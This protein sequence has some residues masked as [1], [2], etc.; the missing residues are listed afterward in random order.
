MYSCAPRWG[1]SVSVLDL[2]LYVR[3]AAGANPVRRAR[4]ASS[5]KSLPSGYALDVAIAWADRLVDPWTKLTARGCAWVQSG[6]VDGPHPE[7]SR[8][9][10]DWVRRA[11]AGPT[12]AVA[13]DV[14][15]LHSGKYGLII[16]DAIDTDRYWVFLRYCG[17]NCFGSD[18]G[19]NVREALL[20]RL[21]GECVW[22]HAHVC[23][24]D[25]DSRR[26]CGM[27]HVIA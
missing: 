14:S 25:A 4:K 16:T 19:A 7:R 27:L 22:W 20:G 5:G 11:A 9:G 12:A 1:V 17:D 21:A 10:R 24:D 8:T 3:V 2:V 26:I 23:R 13:G 6:V 18:A 15:S